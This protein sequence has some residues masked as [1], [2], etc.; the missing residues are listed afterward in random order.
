MN[1]KRMLW[2]DAAK[3]LG[4]TLMFLGHMRIS[5]S[6]LDFIY[7]F[8]MPLFV[9]ISGFLFRADNSFF[10]SL[11]R[12][13]KALILPY[14]YTNTAALFVRLILL[15][16]A[17]AFT[18]SG[19]LGI[20]KAEA[21]ATILAMGFGRNL[22]INTESIGPVWF[23]PFLFCVHLVFL[24]LKKICTSQNLFGEIM[25]F[26]LVV[27]LSFVGYYIGMEIAFLP[28][29]FDASLVA[30]PLFY[31]GTKLKQYRFFEKKYSGAVSLLF[32]LFWI[33]LYQKSGMVALVTRAYESFP[34]CLLVSIAGSIFIVYLIRTAELHSKTALLLKPIAWCGRH[35]ML[36][37]G[38]HT[39]E[40]W[41]IGWIDSIQ[42]KCPNL[43]CSYIA[44]LVLI[45]GI[46]WGI[47]TARK[48][49][50]LVITNIIS[51]KKRR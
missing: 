41:H 10:L 38:I 27:S 3:G 7:S 49:L 48:I 11:K 26:V 32:A 35:S 47:L 34:L 33:L 46:A 37:L 39:I 18:V 31:T 28:W 22:F 30:L 9:I 40:S 13:A 15:L 36:L 25:E 1:R 20:A 42:D 50:S 12:R 44:Y 6:M 14:L 43:F 29:S 17:G 51:V 19:A 8:H 2:I 16:I 4:I 5:E 45:I 24:L 21:K 23:V